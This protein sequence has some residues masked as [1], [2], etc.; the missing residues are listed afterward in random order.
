MPDDKKKKSNAAVAREKLESLGFPCGR[1]GGCSEI[2]GTD[3]LHR[4]PR[5]AQVF[6]LKRTA[7]DLNPWVNLS[8]AIQ[9]P[10]APQSATT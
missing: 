2:G 3:D 9:C 6:C 7:T 4:G 8:I 5:E 10:D 1:S